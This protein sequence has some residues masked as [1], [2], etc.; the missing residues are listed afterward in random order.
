VAKAQLRNASE[1][2]DVNIDDGR[3]GWH[4]GLCRSACRSR[5]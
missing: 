2:V 4:G 5:D 1:G 3:P